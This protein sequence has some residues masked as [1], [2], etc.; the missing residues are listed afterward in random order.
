MQI[1]RFILKR[2]LVPLNILCGAA[3]VLYSSDQNQSRPPLPLRAEYRF[4][5]PSGTRH[6]EFTAVCQRSRQATIVVEGL[7]QGGHVEV[8]VNNERPE[9]VELV[10]TGGLKQG[11]ADAIRFRAQLRAGK[12]Q[13]VVTERPG[14][15]IAR[16]AGTNVWFGTTDKARGHA[17]FSV[18][19]DQLTQPKVEYPVTVSFGPPWEPFCWFSGKFDKYYGDCYAKTI[20]DVS[21]NTGPLRA[22][23]HY[24]AV[25][26]ERNV[27]MPTRITLEPTADG[28][29]FSLRVHQTLRAT[30]PPSWGTNLEF[31]H[32]VVN[33]RYGHDWDDGVPDFVWYRVQ[34]ED[35]P[36]TLPG[37]HTTLVRMDDNTRR[38][39]P[40]PTSTADPTQVGLSGT[41]HT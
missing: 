3:C 25:D 1:I 12:N 18:D 8:S 35:A 14:V 29:A 28:P 22:T 30:G 39:Y 23:L 17:L 31:L 36:D 37:S 5:I 41:H 4:H 21:G 10:S 40:F 32:L 7:V 27:V 19:L 33:R 2:C 15:Q 16:V 38:R 13:V 11:R 26:P 34:R 6:G 20:V 24:T 9:A